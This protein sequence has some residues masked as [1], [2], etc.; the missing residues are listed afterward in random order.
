MRRSSPRIFEDSPFRV[1]CLLLGFEN[2]ARGGGSHAIYYRQMRGYMLVVYIIRKERE[3][4][5]HL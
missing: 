1:S 3:P 4:A 5:L 2:R